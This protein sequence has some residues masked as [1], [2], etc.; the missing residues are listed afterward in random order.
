MNT[1][2]LSHPANVIQHNKHEQIQSSSFRS[3]SANSTAI[4]EVALRSDPSAPNGNGGAYTKL[5][6]AYNE[7][8]VSASSLIELSA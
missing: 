8:R 6:S 5:L 7:L 4:T 1:N 2:P 3:I